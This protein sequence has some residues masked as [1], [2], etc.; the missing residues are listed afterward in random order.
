[1]KSNN[2]NLKAIVFEHPDG[3]RIVLVD[4]T[5]EVTVIK[6]GHEKKEMVYI[7]DD[8]MQEGYYLLKSK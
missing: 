5:F 7:G 4:E 2:P 1:M 8:T 3:E 6:D